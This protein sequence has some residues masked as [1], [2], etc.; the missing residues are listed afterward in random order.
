MDVIT[1]KFTHQESTPMNQ[2]STTSR[3]KL[4]STLYYIALSMSLITAVSGIIAFI[5][6]L[7]ENGRYL[8]KGAASTVFYVFIGISILLMLSLFFTRPRKSEVNKGELKL[9]LPIELTA[10]LPAI[11]LV[12]CCAANLFS[13][14]LPLSLPI[15]IL[16]LLS[17]VHTFDR[18]RYLPA[19]LRVISGFA[20]VLF[21]IA[22][23]VQLYLDKQVEMNSSLKLVLQLALMTNTFAVL[24]DISLDLGKKKS[25]A[26]FAFTSLMFIIFGSVAGVSVTYATFNTNVLSEIFSYYSIYILLE[27]LVYIL[28]TVS[29]SAKI[30]R[31]HKDI[32]NINV[33]KDA[34]Q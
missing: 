34:E 31:A 12:A 2:G 30:T 26:S 1:A 6:S 4:F 7:S 29:V 14:S 18:G 3:Q 11:L 23:T 15:A 32:Y 25:P 10:I 5:C 20:K 24:N 16:A 28:R 8:T 9:P 17:V 27:V 33:R 22:V 13:D 19:S 21:L